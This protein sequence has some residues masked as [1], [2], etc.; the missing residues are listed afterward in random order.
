MDYA[1]YLHDVEKRLTHS[2]GS[3]NWQ[4]S[5]RPSTS[6]CGPWERIQGKPGLKAGTEFFNFAENLAW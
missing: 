5:G 3:T 2:A 1:S 6:C 4:G